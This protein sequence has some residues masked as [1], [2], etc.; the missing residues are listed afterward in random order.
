[1][2]ARR[3]VG[4]AAAAS[5]RAA[6]RAAAAPGPDGPVSAVGPP[7][8]R[9]VVGSSVAFLAGNA[10]AV[11]ATGWAVEPLGDPSWARGLRVV[12]GLGLGA[13]AAFAAIYTAAIA[14]IAWRQRVGTDDGEDERR[15]PPGGASPAVV[16][17][18]T[19]AGRVDDRAFAAALLTAAANGALDLVEVGDD[20]VAWSVEERPAAGLAERHALT[21]V[22]AVV[23]EP[24][25]S[26]RIGRGRLRPGRRFRH[27]VV[28]E[29]AGAGLMVPVIP[30]LLVISTMVLAVLAAG[31][32]F[33]HR[34][35]VLLGAAIGGIGLGGLLRRG[36]GHGY[37]LD[38]L[39][40]RAAWLAYG[41][42]LRRTA[43]LDDLGP[44]GVAIWGEHLA[45]AAALAAA[46]TATAALGPSGSGQV[47]DSNGRR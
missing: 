12:G 11:A 14:T 17:M 41:R 45:Y 8:A 23:A 46:P 37:T 21:A 42:F 34:P 40:A 9:S 22:R 16:A 30:G 26:R 32:G 7:S 13:L 24:D 38:G 6:R 2:R 19:S 39:E 25:G 28:A 43:N 20:V 4:D 5:A 15:D 35:L 27:A 31:V 18:L 44:G 1:M 3:A 33:A 10:F 36:S 29:A 47:Q